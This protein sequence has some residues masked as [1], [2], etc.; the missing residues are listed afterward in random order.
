MM[1]MNMEF[2]IQS[3]VSQKEKNKYCILL[4]IYTE[5]SKMVL[6]NLFAGGNNDPDIE[7]GL[8]GIEGEKEGGMN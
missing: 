3:A 1:W 6:L 4:Y 7:D 5:S 8:L 2:A